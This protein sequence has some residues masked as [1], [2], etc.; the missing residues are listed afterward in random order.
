MAPQASHPPPPPQ[1]A[2]S[3]PKQA[4]LVK[5]AFSLVTVGPKVVKG[6]DVASHVTSGD[7]GS[8]S[9]FSRELLNEWL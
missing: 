2:D 6:P 1:E 9:P 5:S 4:D 7:L 8:K 3:P